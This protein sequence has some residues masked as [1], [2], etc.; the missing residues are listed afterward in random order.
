MEGDKILKVTTDPIKKTV[1]AMKECYSDGARIFEAKTFRES[2][3]MWLIAKSK[4]ICNS[5][6]ILPGLPGL[7]WYIR[8]AQ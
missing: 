2:Q 3:L 6:K 7:E 5:F 4:F 8:S 1:D